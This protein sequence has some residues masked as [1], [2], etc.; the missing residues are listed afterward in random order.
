M[1]RISWTIGNTTVRN[2]ER[3]MEAL[4][5]FKEYIEGKSWDEKSQEEFLQVLIDRGLYKPL[6]KK[7]RE[8]IERHGRIWGS[9]PKKLGFI[10]VEGK[11]GKLSITSVG[12]A[13]LED[14]YLEEEIYLRQLLKL[15]ISDV[16]P[17]YTS[18]K[19][20]HSLGGLTKEEMGIFLFTTTDML[21]VDKVVK[22]VKTFRRKLDKIKGRNEKKKFRSI[23]H[24]KH[25]ANL[26]RDELKERNRIEKIS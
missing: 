1:K 13:L 11:K 3:L 21:E 2:P 5:I 8:E 12:N 15:Q 18:L 4:R 26:Y 19:M 24:I 17:F 25:L 10:H 23:Y 6:E 7:T 16:F 20:I 9:V 22:E 14:K